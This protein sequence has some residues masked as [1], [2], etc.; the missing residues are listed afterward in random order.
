MAYVVSTHFG[1]D[2]Q[3]RASRYIALW[4]GD[5]RALRDSLERITST[6]RKLIDDVEAVNVQSVA[7]A[8]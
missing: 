4:D 3:V 7:D 6:A 8:A 2:V 1:L 5:S